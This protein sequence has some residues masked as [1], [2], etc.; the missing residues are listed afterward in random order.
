MS[1]VPAHAGIKRKR[2]YT[3]KPSGPKVSHV[4]SEESASQPKRETLKSI[5]NRIRGLERFLLKDITLESRTAKTLELKKL[6]TILEIRLA[7]KDQG[8]TADESEQP[9]VCDL[10]TVEITVDEAALAAEVEAAAQAARERLAQKQVDMPASSTPGA[11]Q[12][13]GRLADAV[14]RFAAKAANKAKHTAAIA[15]ALAKQK[16]ENEAAARAKAASEGVSVLAPRAAVPAGDKPAPIPTSEPPPP[17]TKQPKVRRANTD[18]RG[19]PD[20]GTIVPEARVSSGGALPSAALPKQSRAEM[21]AAAVAARRGQLVEAQSASVPLRGN[22]PA[23]GAGPSSIDVPRWDDSDD[24]D[25]NGATL[26]RSAGASEAVAVF[27]ADVDDLPASV[28]KE[29]PVVDAKVRKG[30]KN[31]KD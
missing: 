17:R 27:D 5:K 28:A 2:P 22:A 4:P 3:Y 13:T 14:A 19:T 25:D 10:D 21:L 12:H 24:D 6:R 29:P 9:S 30:K 26:K 11:V 23:F 20:A 8:A 18:A 31:R 7:E 15:A 16:A 1:S